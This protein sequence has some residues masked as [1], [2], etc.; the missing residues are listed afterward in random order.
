MLVV[1][2]LTKT[3]GNLKAV[4]RC[5]FQVEEGTLT[6]LIGPNGAGKS[7]TI[8]LVS[9]FTGA[10]AGSVKFMGTEIMGEAPDAISRRGD[11]RRACL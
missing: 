6:A 10:D 11:G 3:F 4:D 2:G 8:D 9:G 5:S 1:E 7:T